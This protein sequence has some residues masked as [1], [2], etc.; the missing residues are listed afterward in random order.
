MNRKQD[1]HQKQNIHQKLSTL[2]AL[3]ALTAFAASTAFAAGGAPT[4]KAS[5]TALARQTV[6]V[7]TPQDGQRGPR[8]GQSGRGDKD[9][10]GMRMRALAAAPNGKTPTAPKNAPARSAPGAQVSNTQAPGDCGVGGHRGGPDGQ[11]APATPTE[12]AARVQTELTQI[13]ALLARTTNA[14]ARGYLTNARSMIVSGNMR[15]AHDL[16]RAAEALTGGQK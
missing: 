14:K 1:I 16:I 2:T 11:R 8:N 10:T 4:P 6:P 12:A 7:C 9:A 13:D 5:T 15:A 3:I